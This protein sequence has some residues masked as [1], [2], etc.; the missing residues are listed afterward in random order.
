[1]TGPMMAPKLTVNGLTGG[2]RR[3]QQDDGLCVGHGHGYVA[4]AVVAAAE[5]LFDVLAELAVWQAPL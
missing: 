5:H 1:M 3:G 2:R 4:D